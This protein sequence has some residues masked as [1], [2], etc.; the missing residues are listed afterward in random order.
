MLKF[1][2]RYIIRPTLY[3]HAFLFFLDHLANTRLNARKN[4]DDIDMVLDGFLVLYSAFYYYLDI[5]YDIVL[6]SIWFLRLP[7]WKHRDKPFIY[8]LVWATHKTSSKS[9]RYRL[10]VM[11][12]QYHDK[13]VD[14]F[15]RVSSGSSNISAEGD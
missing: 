5:I 6:G 4:P 15:R 13:A 9:W 3:V 11:I 2:M 10:A 12:N 7:E 14:R 1:V 8:R